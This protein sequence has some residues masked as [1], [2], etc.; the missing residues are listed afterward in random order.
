MAFNTTSKNKGGTGEGGT[1]ELPPEGTHAAVLV[2]LVELGTQHNQIDGKDQ[3]KILLA[4][5]LTN[6]QDSTGK[7]FV[8]GRD[9]TQSLNEKAALRQLIKT[10]RGKDLEEDGE[11]NVNFDLGLLLGKPCQVTVSHY[12][13]G[14]G[15]VVA[16]VEAVTRP[17]KGLTV[18]P[19]THEPIGWELE[20]GE[21]IPTD[22]WLPWIF[23]RKVKEKI[24]ESAEW[25]A[26][27][28]A[29]SGGRALERSLAADVAPDNPDDLTF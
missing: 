27:T 19:A 13:T 9:Y 10:W 11:G 16:R 26:R 15:K 29:K 1:Y 7:N 14:S 20:S 24:E 25:K 12:K 28:L 2:A 21:P 3:R 23:G 5:E 8:V 18:P 6:E 17:V 22:Y 4:W